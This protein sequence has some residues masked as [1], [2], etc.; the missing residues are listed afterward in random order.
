VASP[1]SH[2]PSTPASHKSI[3]NANAIVHALP[4]TQEAKVVIT[5][6]GSPG[7]RNVL[8]EQGS[9]AEL[10]Q[11]MHSARIAKRKLSFPQE[12][13]DAAAAAA[14]TAAFSADAAAAAEQKVKKQ[15]LHEKL[16]AK[17]R[18]E[19]VRANRR[20]CFAPASVLVTGENNQVCIIPC[21]RAEPL[22]RLGLR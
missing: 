15:R 18:A 7:A 22:G 8:G 3:T 1:L 2:A 12:L 21:R 9:T 10:E 20:R 6:L 4:N 19:K 13:E 14:P 17:Y 11:V 16:L 5:E